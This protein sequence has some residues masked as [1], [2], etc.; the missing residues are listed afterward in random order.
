MQS[1]YNKILKCIIFIEII[2]LRIN[3][4]KDFIKNSIEK[5]TAF[6]KYGVLPELVGKWYTKAASM[7]PSNSK[8]DASPVH[9]TNQSHLKDSATWCYCN[10]SE[11]C[12]NKQCPIEW[13]HC[14]CLRIK[15]IAKGNGT[16]ETVEKAKY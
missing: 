9:V 8:E 2:R 10:K 16:A 6:Y 11:S 12:D 7:S 5:A 3:L 13:H 15:H 14:T 4:D 1:T